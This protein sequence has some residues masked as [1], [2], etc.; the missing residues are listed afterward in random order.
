MTV[1]Y[2]NVVKATSY[3]KTYRFKDSRDL[4]GYTLRVQLR[5]ALD[6]GVVNG[7]DRMITAT[8]EGNTKFYLFLSASDL[9]VPV[10]D[11]VLG[12][13]VANVSTGEAKESVEFLRVTKE[14]VF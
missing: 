10:G 5:S 13:E 9:D 11:Y 1:S 7:I 2:Q 8:Q 6:G 12:A 4:T 14:W 3:A